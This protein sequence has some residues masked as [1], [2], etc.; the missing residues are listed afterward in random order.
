MSDLQDIYFRG[1]IA[2]GH[3]M[4]V[5]KQ[6]LSEM[7][8][9][10]IAQ[11]QKLFSGRPVVI[12]RGL[13]RTAA[14]QYREALFKAGALVEL[15]PTTAGATEENAKIN[16]TPAVN[17]TPARY[18]AGAKPAPPTELSAE[19]GLAPVGSNVLAVDERKTVVTVEVD[20]SALS[21]DAPGADLLRASE[22]KTAPAVNIDTS[23]LQIAAP[24]G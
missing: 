17:D 4:V 19:P 1:D 2:P 21:L 24:E 18:G 7:F 8:R 23:H 6:R 14:Q 11:V 10:D 16:H 12:R 15:Q 5:V 3:R 9:L 20:T 13:N 22:R